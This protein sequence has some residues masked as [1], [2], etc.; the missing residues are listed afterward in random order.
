M[1]TCSWA[2]FSL[3]T[4]DQRKRRLFK[5][6]MQTPMF[7]SRL[8]LSSHVSS[9]NIIAMTSYLLWV[10]PSCVG[11]SFPLSW[12]PPAM[13][14]AVPFSTASSTILI[15]HCI[16][17]AVTLNLFSVTLTVLYSWSSFQTTS[18][19]LLFAI[20]EVDKN[21]TKPYFWG[22]LIFSLQLC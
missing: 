20:L 18:L 3:K 2:R 13:D 7:P 4:L 5:M 6:M 12:L 19:I 17:F 22:T 11:T 14:N 10:N 15:C 16:F 9:Q 8:G 21:K 1:E